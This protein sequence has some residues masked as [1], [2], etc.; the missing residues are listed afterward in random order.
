[1]FR[2][3]LREMRMKRGLTQQ[4]MADLLNVALR[5]YQ[6][7]EGGTRSPSFDVLLKISDILC[8]STDYL[9]G[10]DDISTILHPNDSD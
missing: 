3:R 10:K 4:K 7:Y 2:K 6:N 9:L 8:V 5:T 1:M